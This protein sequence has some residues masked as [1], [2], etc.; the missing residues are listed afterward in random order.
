MVHVVMAPELLSCGAFGGASLC[1]FFMLANL[2]VQFLILFLFFLYRNVKKK[3]LEKGFY[4]SRMLRAP[5]SK[6]N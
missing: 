5:Q 2:I 3:S 4:V 6:L 1:V